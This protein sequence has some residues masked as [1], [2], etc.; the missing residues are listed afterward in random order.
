M[1]GASHV[2]IPSDPSHPRRRTYRGDLVV[3][4]YDSSE[5]SQPWCSFQNLSVS[6]SL[7]C[8]AKLGSPFVHSHKIPKIIFGRKIERHHSSFKEP[9]ATQSLDLN[10]FLLYISA[11]S[12]SPLLSLL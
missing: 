10:L 2:C 6:L 1:I 5:N 4:H 8:F 7:E 12:Q 9:R 11:T 3:I